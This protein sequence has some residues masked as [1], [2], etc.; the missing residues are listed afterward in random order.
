VLCDVSQLTVL[1]GLA[2]AAVLPVTVSVPLLAL[3]LENV[4]VA[5]FNVP[6]TVPPT[7]DGIVYPL[8]MLPEVGEKALPLEKLAVSDPMGDAVRGL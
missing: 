6:V 7:P 1:T 5:P 4:M 8:A 3:P 2:V